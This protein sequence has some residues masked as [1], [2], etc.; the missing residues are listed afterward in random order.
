M[1]PKLQ[2]ELQ[3]PPPGDDELRQIEGMQDEAQALLAQCL[4][5]QMDM[6]RAITHPTNVHTAA[7]SGALPGEPQKMFPQGDA[8]D[9][10]G[11]GRHCAR[12]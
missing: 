2:S 1:R 5:K 3:Q 10:A 8:Q 12:R 9:A 6:E 4:Q 11:A 7:A